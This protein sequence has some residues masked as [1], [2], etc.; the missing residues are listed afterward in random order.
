MNNNQIKCVNALIRAGTEVNAA[1][2]HGLTPLM[3]ATDNKKK[4]MDL[5]IKTGADVNKKDSEGDTPLIHSATR[6]SE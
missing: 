2:N 3:L 6:S 4:C 1:D 5:L